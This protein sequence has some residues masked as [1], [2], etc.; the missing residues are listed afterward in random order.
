MNRYRVS[1]NY[2]GQTVSYETTAESEGKAKANAASRLAFD[3]KVAPA[4]IMSF[5][6]ANPL[7]I[8]VRLLGRKII[9]PTIKDTKSFSELTELK[10][11]K[12]L[13]SRDPDNKDEVRGIQAQI[14]ELELRIRNNN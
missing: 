7:S 6:Q 8:E 4:S 9:K 11:K 14:Q 13:L 5:L 2:K 1:I 3:A 10:R 12:A